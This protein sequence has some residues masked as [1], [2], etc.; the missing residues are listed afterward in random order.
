MATNFGRDAILSECGLKFYIFGRGYIDE[1]D[2]YLWGVTAGDVPHI[3][4]TNDFGARPARENGQHR[5]P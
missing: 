2:S 1:G 4:C 5:W 3:R